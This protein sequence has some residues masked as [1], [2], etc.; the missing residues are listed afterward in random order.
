MPFDAFN[1]NRRKTGATRLRSKLEE[2]VQWHLDQLGIENNYET[3][4]VNY[5]IKRSYTPDF[6]LPGKHPFSIEVKG[7]LSSEDRQKLLAVVLANP[8]MRL[9]VA[10]QQ[11]NQLIR[12]GSKR[13]VA[14]WAT[15]HGIAW[16]PIPIPKELLMKWAN[17][18]RCT[19]PVLSATAA[20]QHR[21]MTAAGSPASAADIEKDPRKG[22][23]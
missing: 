6:N 12:K 19:F 8:D 21:A 14:E 10:F 5:T 3:E 20:M 7:W 22:E 17:G 16:T 1:R 11:P 2:R 4:T 9:L 15:K 13:T 18:E 23:L